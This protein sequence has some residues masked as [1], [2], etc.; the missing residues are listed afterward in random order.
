M[1]VLDGSG[2]ALGTLKTFTNLNANSGFAQQSM[3]LAQYAGKTVT[4][5]FTGTND[6]ED[7]TSW[8]IDDTALTV[9]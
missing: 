5:E 8:V 2:N 6:Y 4:L 3:S 1:Q 7:P 9:S